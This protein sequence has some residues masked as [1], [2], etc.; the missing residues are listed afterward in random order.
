MTI[1]GQSSGEVRLNLGV[2]ILGGVIGATGGSKL[3]LDAAY[4][5]AK[6]VV[7][8]FTDVLE[9]KIEV[10]AALDQYLGDADVSPFSVHVK[11]LLESDEVYVT[12]SVLKSARITV[13]GRRSDGSALNLDVPAIEKLVGGALDVSSASGQESKVTYK[14]K[15]PLAFGFQ[16]VRLY[17]EQGR[18]TAFKVAAT[19]VRMRRPINTKVDLLAFPGNFGRL[20]RS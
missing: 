18:Y 4:K 12:T 14:G 5:D 1:S 20:G 2:S 19:D 15:R 8:E 6:T 9:D 13:V 10:T 7:F 16:A 3:G 17:Y 11:A